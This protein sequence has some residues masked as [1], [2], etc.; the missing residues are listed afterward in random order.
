MNI[1]VRLYGSGKFLCRPD[2]SWER[3]NKDLFAPD[4]VSSYLWTPILFA[5]ISKAGKCVGR[6]F[7]SR[8]WDAVSY[9]ALL[10]VGD[11]LDGSPESMACA[12][13]AD[14]TSV[15]PFPMYDKAT[16]ES[17]LN[18][19]SLR[20]DSIE[21]YSTVTEGATEMIE[22]AITASSA[23]VSLRIGDIIAIELAPMQPMG[24]GVQTEAHGTCDRSPEMTEISGTFCDNEL[25]KFNIIM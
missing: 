9:G 13:C 3:E 1:I 24:Q 25:F 22:E 21:A 7:A 10:Y 8:Y 19:F 2:T 15:L 20:I 6:K 14:R 4:S 23:I 16:L 17:G 11:M 12:S 18:M 5:R